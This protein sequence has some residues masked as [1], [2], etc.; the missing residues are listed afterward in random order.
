MKISTIDHKTSGNARFTAYADRRGDVVGYGATRKEAIAD[1]EKKIFVAG[2]RELKHEV[3]TRITSERNRAHHAARPYTVK[4]AA[5]QLYGR[6]TNE[7]DAMN[8]AIKI[9]G[10]AYYRGKF[11]EEVD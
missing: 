7:T 3:Q 1:L 8:A 2:I 11:I 10:T 6:Y 4:D 9:G 5:G